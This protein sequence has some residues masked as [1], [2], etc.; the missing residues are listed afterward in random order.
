MYTVGAGKEVGGS[1]MLEQIIEP[2]RCCGPNSMKHQ[3]LRGCSPGD[4][5]GLPICRME[6]NWRNNEAGWT[7]E[8]AM[9][10]RLNFPSGHCSLS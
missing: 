1:A 9:A 2:F 3:L 6:W 7:T 8:R 10:F 4:P 5:V